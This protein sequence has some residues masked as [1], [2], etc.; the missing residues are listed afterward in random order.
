M[1]TST[2]GR[3]ALGVV[4]GAAGLLATASTARRGLAP[5]EEDVFRSANDLPDE[6]YPAIWAPMQYG[7]F[8]TTPVLAAIAAL[9]GSGASPSRSS[10]PARSPG[11]RPRDRGR[12]PSRATERRGRGRA[13]PRARG[14]RAR[15]PFGPCRRLRRAHNGSAAVPA[16]PARA[17]AVGLAGVVS[18]SRV[19]IGAHLPLDVL[20]GAALGIAVGS[21]VRLASEARRPRT[22]VTDADADRPDREDRSAP[23]RRAAPAPAGPRAVGWAWAGAIVVG[24]G[25]VASLAFAATG[26]VTGFDRATLDAFA[27]VRTA[28][29][30][31]VAKALHVSTALAMIMALRIGTVLALAVVKRFRHLVV[32]L[33]TFVL[34][35]WLVVNLLS[36]PLPRPTVPVLADPGTFAFRRARSRRS[37]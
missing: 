14:G 35:D 10:P 31:D 12:G 21:A 4:V 9:R 19:Y 3:D 22:G 23:L 15:V 32:F 28:S 11:S 30:T 26:E 29:R 7:T 27:E 36:V 17:G 2:R 25:V 16:G 20:G 13:Y 24:L 33:A 5:G 34:T 8:A 18:F 6:L 1:G 37:R